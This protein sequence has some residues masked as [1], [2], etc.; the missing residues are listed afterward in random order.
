MTV[1]A[2]TRDITGRVNRMLRDYNLMHSSQTVANLPT[3]VTLGTRTFVTDANATT[4]NSVVAG[5]GANLVP[6]YHDGTDWRI[7]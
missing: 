2:P 7:G 3:Q 1:E 5:G 6:V 4:F